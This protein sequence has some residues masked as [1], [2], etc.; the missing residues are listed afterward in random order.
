MVRRLVC[1]WLVLLLM[2]GGAAAKEAPAVSA[3]SVVLM[4][5]DSGRVLYGHN[6]D[7]PA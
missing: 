6:E 5:A 2:C 7:E 3:A 1:I 4:D